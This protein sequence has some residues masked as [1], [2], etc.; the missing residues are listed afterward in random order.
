MDNYLILK[1]VGLII[2]LAI[3]YFLLRSY[4]KVQRK[5]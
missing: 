3:I 5:H 2:G 1:A 4:K